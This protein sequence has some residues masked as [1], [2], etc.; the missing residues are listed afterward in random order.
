M[1]HTKNVIHGIYGSVET[2][3]RMYT[4][5]DV[6]C[7]LV[8]LLWELPWKIPSWYVQCLWFRVAC[9][10]WHL[11]CKQQFSFSQA[12]WSISHKNTPSYCNL[13]HFE[14]NRV[15]CTWSIDSHQ[16]V[17]LNIHQSSW[18]NIQSTIRKMKM[19]QGMIQKHK[20]KVFK[21][22]NGACCFTCKFSHIRNN[23]RSFSFNVGS[24]FNVALDVKYTQVL[25]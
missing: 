16:W 14:G 13:I 1:G 21:T 17:C 7:M 15:H 20:A 19:L 5:V 6:T 12:Q 2:V 10:Y 24:N 22:Q 4:R 23:P 18:E 8:C 3:Y 25:C 11:T 9:N